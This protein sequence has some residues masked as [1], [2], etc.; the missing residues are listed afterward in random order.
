MLLIIVSIDAPAGL[1][2]AVKEVAEASALFRKIRQHA[3]L[4]VRDGL[5]HQRVQRRLFKR[6]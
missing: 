1:A 3:R 6:V 4:V 2:Q 5:L